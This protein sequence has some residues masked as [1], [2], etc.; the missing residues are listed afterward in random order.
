MQITRLLFWLLYFVLPYSLPSILPLIALVGFVSYLSR[1]AGRTWQIAYTS[2][3]FISAVVGLSVGII[4]A[5]RK[6][7]D[8]GTLFPI[9]GTE[10]TLYWSGFLS[11]LAFCIGTLALL[12]AGHALARWISHSTSQQGRQL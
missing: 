10:H 2:A 5:A 12:S 9:E 8:Y 3:A 4:R 6:V 1:A 7:Q 11:A